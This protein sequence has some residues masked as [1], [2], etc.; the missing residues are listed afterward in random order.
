MDSVTNLS[1]KFTILLST[2]NTDTHQY[3]DQIARFSDTNNN[4]YY[5]CMYYGQKSRSMDKYIRTGAY[6]VHCTPNGE[7]VLRGQVT[8]CKVTS[9]VREGKQQYCLYV[10]PVV[11]NTVPVEYRPDTSCNRIR[12]HIGREFRIGDE[13]YDWPGAF[14]S[15]IIPLKK[16]SHCVEPTLEYAPAAVQHTHDAYTL[17][18]TLTGFRKLL[19]VPAPFFDGTPSPTAS[20]RKRVSDADV[21]AVMPRMTNERQMVLAATGLS[22][23]QVQAMDVL[24]ALKKR[25]SKQRPSLKKTK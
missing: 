20:K 22:V 12:R 25:T 13:V 8:H 21:R 2:P 15:G 18:H 10:Y 14:M 23:A 5:R 17:A 7:Y 11:H 1:D 19:T 9:I 3:F 24:T 16:V 6:L 4:T